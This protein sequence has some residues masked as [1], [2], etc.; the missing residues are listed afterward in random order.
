MAL[1]EGRGGYTL[2]TDNRGMVEGDAVIWRLEEELLLDCEPGCSRPLAERFRRYLV[3][4]DVEIV[5]ADSLVRHLAL[6]GPRAAEALAALDLGTPDPA[7]FS[8]VRREHPRWGEIHVARRSRGDIEIHDIFHASG[9]GGDLRERLEVV[10]AS[11]GGGTCGRESLEVLRIRAGIPR[12]PVD[13][14]PKVLAP[15]LRLEEGVVGRSKG[16]YIGQE[17]LNRIRTIGRVVRSLVL[18]GFGQGEEG[19]LPEGGS[20]EVEGRRVGRLCSMARCPLAGRTFALALV[21]R[22]HARKGAVLRL[23]EGGSVTV[24]AD[25]GT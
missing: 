20:L 25:A 6:L 5:E 21:R 23:G 17:V 16:C 19:S 1:P 14:T 9:V 18:V 11:L 15:E 10:L 12:F 13:M 8:I 22:E 24:L 3:A 4:D 2:V 7:P